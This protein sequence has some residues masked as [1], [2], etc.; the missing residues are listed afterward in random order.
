M[1]GVDVA[2]FWPL[3]QQF[4]RI[5]SV[6]GAEQSFLRAIRRELDEIGVK[7]T[8]YEGLLVAEG[9]RP[10]SLYLSAHVDRHGLMCTGPHEYQYAA[11]V[12]KYRADHLGNSVSEQTFGRLAGRF[13]RQAVEAY[14]SWSGRYLGRGVI[15]HSYLCER[16]KNIIFEVEALGDLPPGTAVAYSDRL[17]LDDGW[18]Q[19]QLD[20]VLSVCSAIHLHRQGFAGTTFFTAQEEAGRSWRYI[21]EWFQRVDRATSELLVLD[22]SPF[23]T[24][25]LARAQEVVLR[26][27]DANGAF[28][29]QAVARLERRCRDLGISYVFKDELVEAENAARATAGERPKSLGSTELGRLVD[30]SGGTLQGATL[31]VPTI[32]YHTA[33]ERAHVDAIGAFLRLLSS[34]TVE[35]PTGDRR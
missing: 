14:E 16:R 32:G 29:A 27:R 35:A 19:A 7:T 30:A 24:E 18:A 33:Y 9:A 10:E 4:V 11:F 3:L 13:D 12:A 15:T 34:L 8:H 5:P 6:V 21:L 17:V 26:R 20:N 22:T 23:D 25:E 28:D 1:P 2:A 31:Q